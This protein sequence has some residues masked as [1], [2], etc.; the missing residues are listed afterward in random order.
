MALLS[1]VTGTRR[2]MKSDVN[3]NRGEV[4]T[5]DPKAGGGRR[6]R[7]ASLTIPRSQHWGPVRGPAFTPPSVG[8]ICR[9]SATWQRPSARPES[10]W[11]PHRL[12]RC[13]SST[14]GPGWRISSFLQPVVFPDPGLLEG[15]Y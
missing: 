2:E 15:I 14:P 8:C 4:P 11:P 10:T 1:N 9:V 3:F 13:S 6:Q 12:V 5:E 7:P